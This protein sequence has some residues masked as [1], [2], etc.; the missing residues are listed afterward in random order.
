[1][2]VN[3]YLVE[4]LVDIG[5][6]MCIMAAA[7]VRELGLMHMV[8]GSE[9]YKTTSGVVTHALGRIDEVPI[10]VGGV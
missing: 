7:V 8:F 6:S 1:V 3:N 10:K 5:A 9:T 2:E 4:E